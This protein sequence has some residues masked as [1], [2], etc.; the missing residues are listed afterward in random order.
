MGLGGQ[1]TL[2]SSASVSSSVDKAKREPPG[3]GSG[4]ADSSTEGTEG[5]SLAPSFQVTCGVE[6]LM[7]WV[8]VFSLL[9]L[10]PTQGDKGDPGPDGERGEKGQEGLKGEDGLPGPPGIT[11]IRVSVHLVA[12]WGSRGEKLVPVQAPEK[13]SRLSLPCSPLL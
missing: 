4:E 8:L 10:P 9:L 11:G 5:N 13:S 7:T 12:A 3:K 1:L 2:L 6:L